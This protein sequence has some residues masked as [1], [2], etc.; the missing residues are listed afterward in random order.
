MDVSMYE[1]ALAATGRVVAGTDREQFN[2][3]TPCT[4][5]DVR[6]LLNHII[7][8]CATFAAGATGERRAMDASDYTRG[9]YV[10]AY[11]EVSGAALQAFASPGALERPFTLPTGDTPGS[12]ALGLAVADAVV[13]GWDLATATSQEYAI[14][15][16]AA[17]S[18]YG[19]TSGMMAP[20]GS[21]PRGS[22]FADPVGAAEDAS[23]ATRMLAY[24]GRKQ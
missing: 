15:D 21:Y 6:T 16:A 14:E 3:P 19:M 17:E 8:G 9:D 11:Q 1:Q 24:L 12:V 7:G 22:A 2:D 18:I 13:H 10:A 23:P 5:W 20:L 4:D